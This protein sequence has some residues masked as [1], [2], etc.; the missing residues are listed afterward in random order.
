MSVRVAVAGVGNCANALIQGVHFYKDADPDEAIPGLMHSRF[1]PYS[2]G[3]IEFVAAFDVDARKVGADL[4]D[5]IWA[6]ENKPSS[7]PRWSRPAHRAARPDSGRL[8]KYYLETIEESTAPVVDVARRCVSAARMCWSYLPVGSDEATKYYAQ[9]AI[10]AGVAFV[11]AAARVHRER[12]G[13]G[14]EVHRGRHP[15]RGRR[16]QEPARRDDHAPRACAA[17]RGSAASCSTA[18]TS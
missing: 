13:L 4:A 6:S 5:A 12:S 7:S 14:R 18:P 11:N 2:V 9:A 16:H 15:D 17:V 1:G 3:D 8:G 10:D